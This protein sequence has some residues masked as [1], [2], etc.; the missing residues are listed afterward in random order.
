MGKKNR[1]VRADRFRQQ[2]TENVIGEDSLVG[3]EVAEGDIVKIKVPV[4]LDEESMD[5]PQ[6][7]AD[8]DSERERALVVLGYNP[9]RTAE[10]QLDAVLAA[11]YTYRDIAAWLNTETAAAQEALGKFRYRG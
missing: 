10:E 1:V 4:L 7:I 11:G 6:R 3:I 8:A 5:Y 9:D 2:L